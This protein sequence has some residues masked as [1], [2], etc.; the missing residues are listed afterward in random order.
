MPPR[1]APIQ[2]VIVPI[3]RKD[4][5]REV[6]LA[7]AREVVARCQASAPTWTTGTT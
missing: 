5:E 3:Y 4:E 7:K 6:V 1:L 2:V